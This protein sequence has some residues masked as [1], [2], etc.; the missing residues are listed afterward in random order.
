MKRFQTWCLVA[1]CWCCLL[2]FDLRR[3]FT[4]RVSIELRSTGR[5]RV[6]SRWYITPTAMANAMTLAACLYVKPVRCLQHS[7]CLAKLLRVF[8][9][10]AQVVIG[11]RARPFLSHAWVEVDAQALN[12]TRNYAT[13]LQ[14][15]HS[16]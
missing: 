16:S 4:G 3:R 13:K 5:V 6:P 12:E 2:A 10:Q 15:L 14:V 11:Y 9:I 1:L 8:G 7:L